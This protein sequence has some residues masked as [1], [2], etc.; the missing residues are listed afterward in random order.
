MPLSDYTIC[1]TFLVGTVREVS[2]REFGGLKAGKETERERKGIKTR[3][4]KTRR[5]LMEN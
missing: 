5:T 4:K 1:E 3:L 2:F